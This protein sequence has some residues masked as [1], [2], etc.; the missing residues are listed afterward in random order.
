MRYQMGRFTG[1]DPDRLTKGV[2]NL[3]QDF[4]DLWAEI[5]ASCK[6]KMSGVAYSMWFGS[7]TPVS[8]DGAA[9]TVTVP[10]VMYK[11]VVEQNYMSYIDEAFQERVGFPVKLVILCE[12]EMETE[13][14]PVVEDIL[15]TYTFS[16]YVMGESNH[17]AYAASMAVAENFPV[18]KYNPLVIYGNSGVGKTHLALAIFNYIRARH[19]E[20]KLLYMRTEEF[21]NDVITSIHESR[22]PELRERLRSVDLLLLDDIHFIAGKEAVQE[23]F[24]NTFNALYQDNKQIIVTCDRPIRD[25]K[26]LEERIQSRLTQGLNVDI[27]APDFE[28]R[29]GII[30]RNAQRLSLTLDDDTVFYIAEQIKQNVRQLE[31]VV[32]K[33]HAIVESD[34]TEIN[35]AIVNN[36][37]RDIRNDYQPEP[38]TVD[39]ILEEVSR[40]Y[41]T[42][43]DEIT[44]K[45]QNARVSKARQIAMYV[46]REVTQMPL[47]TIGS[48]FDRDHSTVHY[49]IK[50]AEALLKRVPR[51][52]E[53]V[54]DIIKNLQAR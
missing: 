22:M 31:G 18:I 2:S 41:Q 37:I 34:A 4:K 6:E 23:E 10:T 44:S 21:T 7:L 38:I 11:N 39:K 3:V 40:T 46:I 12:D 27:Q 28:T 13:A 45:V 54:G 17:F 29:V 48:Y 14:A 20:L 50:K 8:F 33:L 42:T 16:N 15:S 53:M 5:S 35:R 49:A 51:E 43:P 36:V 25:V 30:R 52:K 24:F 9:F 32:K 47:G 1:F 26:T 19:P